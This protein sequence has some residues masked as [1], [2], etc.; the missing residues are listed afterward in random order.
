MRAMLILGLV[1]VIACTSE[2]VTSPAAQAITPAKRSPGV[3]L[4]SVS[5][6]SVE[7]L[8]VCG[9][10]YPT[11]GGVI[12]GWCST[13]RVL[14][15][16]P[17]AKKNQWFFT[18]RVPG[19]DAP[20]PVPPEEDFTDHRFGVLH[21]HTPLIRH[22]GVYQFNSLDIEIVGGRRYLEVSVRDNQ[23]VNWGVFQTR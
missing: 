17:Y 20:G 15:L 3:A 4:P 6:P 9:P 10:D 1:A 23:P 21:S 18:I 13:V 8:F 5:D 14:W 19:T 7:P 2:S 16:Q 12:E 22:D 11:D